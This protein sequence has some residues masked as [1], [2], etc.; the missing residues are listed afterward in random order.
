MVVALVCCISVTP[1]LGEEGRTKVAGASL[2]P[3]PVG[4]VYATWSAAGGVALLELDGAALAE[5]GLSLPESGRGD[6]TL[7]IKPQGATLRL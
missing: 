6:L 1:V 7:A 4:E 3:Q 2:Q 5:Y